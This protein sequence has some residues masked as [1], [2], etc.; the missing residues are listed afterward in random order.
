MNIGILIPGYAANA[1]DWPDPVLRRLIGGLA[2]QHDVR[3][4][5]LHYP[6]RHD[7]YTIDG[8]PVYSL[9]GAQAR[10][11][12][13]LRLWAEAQSVLS[14]LH[15]QR[16]FDLLHAMWIDEPGY[17]AVRAGR[18]FG[19]PVVTSVLGGEFARID[20]IGYGL[21]RSR[22]S[23]W[24]VRRGMQANA[25]VSS[26]STVDQ[27]I[28]ASRIPLESER[29]HRIVLGVD[30][31]AFTPGGQPQP[32]HLLHVGSLTPV[33]DQTTLLHAFALLPP[34]VTLAIIGQGPLRA[35]LEA[36]AAQLGVTERVTFVGHVDHTALVGHYRRAYLHVM[37][38]RSETIML[39]VLEAAACGVPTVGTA[40]GAL[41]DYPG[42][43]VGVPVRDPQALADAIRA[44]L[45]DR[46]R[47][48]AL[49]RNARQLAADQLSIQTSI[50]RTLALYDRL[51]ERR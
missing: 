27:G 50:A 3:I 6:H 22:L 7:H 21:Q 19:I 47:R 16:P 18:R 15:R 38:S 42:L 9:G 29:L 35:Q 10:G 28:A 34:D 44:L 24:L 49:G 32:R 36:L 23:R 4:I 17:L 37:A 5:A 20:D 12:R 33:K 41:A 1:H 14:E 2:Q 51:I 40:T 43:G 30:A 48:D 45:D 13:R 46:S 31:D 11:L 39:A 25:V 8:I 26:G